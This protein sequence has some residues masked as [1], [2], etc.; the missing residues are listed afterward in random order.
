M[1]RSVHF[2]EKKNLIGVY[3]YIVLCRDIF[4]CADF[5]NFEICLDSLFLFAICVLFI[6]LNLYL[7]APLLLT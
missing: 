3:R 7:T 1:M 4:F 2:F 5:W 6:I